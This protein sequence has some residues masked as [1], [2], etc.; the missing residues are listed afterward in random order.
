MPNTTKKTSAKVV[1]SSTEK[2]K[3]AS[4]TSPSSL[5]PLNNKVPLPKN[6]FEAK[7]HNQAMF[8]TIMMER[9]SRRQGTHRVKS[10]AEVSGTGKKP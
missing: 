5:K 1:K 2:S 7:I 9:A 10:R 4:K 8:D 3:K 6:V